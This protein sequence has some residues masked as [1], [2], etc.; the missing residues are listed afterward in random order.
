LLTSSVLPDILVE[1][2]WKIELSGLRR[3]FVTQQAH[4]IRPMVRA[5]IKL[6]SI[7]LEAKPPI[8]GWRAEH[9][10]SSPALYLRPL[11][12]FS[13][14]SR[15]YPDFLSVR[16]NSNWSESEGAHRSFDL[17]E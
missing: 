14:H 11:Q 1:R 17:A 4:K 2:C 6:G 16:A 8:V 15:T 12:T 9:E 13:D 10:D 3:P 5:R 7:G